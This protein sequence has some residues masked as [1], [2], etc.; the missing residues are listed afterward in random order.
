MLKL[1]PK[2]M[3]LSDRD[4]IISEVED[5]QEKL[6]QLKGT[7]KNFYGKRNQIIAEEKEYPHKL[8]SEIAADI[9]VLNSEIKEAKSEIKEIRKEYP[10]YFPM[11]KKQETE[12]ESV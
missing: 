3:E 7:L 1:E 6:Q 8:L 12:D 10:E 9:Q 2:T 5:L 11:K 4:R